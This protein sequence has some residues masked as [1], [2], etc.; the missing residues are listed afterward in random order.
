MRLLPLPFPDELQLDPPAARV[1][2]VTDDGTSLAPQVAAR[3]RDAGWTAVLVRL[4]WLAAPE[5]GDDLPWVALPQADEA[6]LRALLSTVSERYGAP[7]SFIFVSPPAAGTLFP[8][9]GRQSLKTAFLFAKLLHPHLTAASFQRPHFVAVTRMDGRLGLGGDGDAIQ[10][11]FSGLVKT[12]A[13]EWPSVFCRAVDLA[14]ALPSEQAAALLLAEIADPNRRL[15]E[16]GW[17]AEG[18]VT[19]IAQEAVR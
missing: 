10:G 11:G 13:L 14:P 7:Q 3:L 5:A 17:N 4:P 19:R 16:V 15:T 8:A 6:A 9:A 18:R 12:L 2:L 1:C